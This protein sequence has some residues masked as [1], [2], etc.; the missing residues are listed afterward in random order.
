MSLQLSTGRKSPANHVKKVSRLS[1]QS[2]AFQDRDSPGLEYQFRDSSTE[3]S[4][5]P[6]LQSSSSSLAMEVR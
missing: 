1:L 3:D 5:Q 4:I 6:R 2:R